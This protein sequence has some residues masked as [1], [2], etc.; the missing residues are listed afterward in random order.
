MGGSR[1]EGTRGQ[2]RTALQNHTETARK[3]KA[4]PKPQPPA[5][6][7]V[8]PG[9]VGFHK[10]GWGRMGAAVLLLPQRRASPPRF[11]RFQLLMLKVM[12]PFCD[13]SHSEVSQLSACREAVFG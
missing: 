5:L 6:E 2:A 13:I 4:G 3:Q 7:P 8:R 9:G 1:E 12:N 10:R 11:S